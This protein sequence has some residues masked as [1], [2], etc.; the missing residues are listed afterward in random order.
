[1]FDPCG[2]TLLTI[3]LNVRSTPF[4]CGF[5]KMVIRQQKQQLFRE[6]YPTKSYLGS[7]LIGSKK[8]VFFVQNVVL[9]CSYVLHTTSVSNGLDRHL[10]VKSW[11]FIFQVHGNYQL[12]R[13]HN[14]TGV[15]PDTTLSRT[16]SCWFYKK[17]GHMLTY[18]KLDKIKEKKRKNGR[19]HSHG[20]SNLLSNFTISIFRWRQLKQLFGSCTESLDANR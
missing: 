13:V 15:S 4:Q 8:K 19:N 14:P 10:N 18:M 5:E 2:R 9:R 6:L 3:Q 11:F 1:M 20:L 16:T 12:V 7:R 17:Q